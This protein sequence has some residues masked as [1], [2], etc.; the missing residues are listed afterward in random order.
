MLPVA[1]LVPRHYAFLPPEI[2]GRI[3]TPGPGLFRIVKGDGTAG[4][5]I[6]PFNVLLI[7]AAAFFVSMNVPEYLDSPSLTGTAQ[8][9]ERDNKQGYFLILKKRLSFFL[10]KR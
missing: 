6:R 5:R 8:I 4:C 7:R 2:R 1:A 3:F 9:E 10:K